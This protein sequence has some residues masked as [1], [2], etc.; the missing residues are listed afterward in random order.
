[1]LGLLFDRSPNLPQFAGSKSEKATFTRYTVLFPPFSLNL[2]LLT[3]A[4]EHIEVELNRRPA[5]IRVNWVRQTVTNCRAVDGDGADLEVEYGREAIHLYLERDELWQSNA[6]TTVTVSMWAAGDVERRQP[7]VYPVTVSF[8]L[9]VKY[10]NGIIGDDIIA[11]ESHDVECTFPAED[12][13]EEDD[14]DDA[15]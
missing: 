12:G 4:T 9:S 15:W 13:D 7:L 8:S 5:D 2:L 1:M 11:A 14:D 3:M 6:T 10:S